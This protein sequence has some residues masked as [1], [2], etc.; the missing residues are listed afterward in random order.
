MEQENFDKIRN[1]VNDLRNE[2][3]RF[4]TIRKNIGEERLKE[5]FNTIYPK[6][7]ITEIEKITG[8]PD[9]T[10]GRRFGELNIPFIRHHI[11]TK[12]FPG[13]EDA[14]IVITKNNEAFRAVTVKITPK[15]AYLIGFTLGD[16]SVQKYMIEVFNKDRKLREILFQHLKPYG[17]ITEEERE[18]GLWRLRLSNGV[19]ANLIKDEK[20]IREDTLNY[21]FSNDELAR[22]FIAAFW[23][24]EG[25]VRKQYNYYHIYLYNSNEYLISK[26]CGF[27]NNK[28]I[29]FSIHKRPTRDKES[30]ILDH[31]VKSKKILVRINIHKPSW[32]KWTNEIGLLM[33]H[34]KKKEVIN[35]ILKLF[36]GKQNE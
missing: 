12:A 36:G 17:T 28:K 7:A 16:G 24:A 32:T 20:G 27:L 8:I 11:V 30:F 22:Q 9:S 18:N 15:L 2:K 29:K 4:K 31:L 10:L 25:T 5:F 33:N 34:T 14:E 21:I 35:Q 3:R 1:E 6:F 26:V 23:D 13:N 19:I